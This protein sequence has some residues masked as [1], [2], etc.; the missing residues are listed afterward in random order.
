M[1]TTKASIAAII[2][3]T[4]LTTTDRDTVRRAGGPALGGE[5]PG[6]WAPMGWSILPPW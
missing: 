2:A 1:L 4:T 5:V 3:S 6:N